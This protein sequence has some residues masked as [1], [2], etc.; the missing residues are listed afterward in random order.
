MFGK[1]QKLA[2][3]IMYSP[4][5]LINLHKI[6][7][8][9]FKKHLFYGTIAH[10]MKHVH[11]EECETMLRDIIAMVRFIELECGWHYISAMLSYISEASRFT[12]EARFAHIVSSGLTTVDERKIMTLA[13]KWMQQG[14]QRGREEGVQQ[15]LK[16]M[17]QET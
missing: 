15:G 17:Q 14:M 13:E 8:S 7:D 11:D 5:Q 6:S 12:D 3:D 4:Y 2:R 9:E 1:R 10:T 16:R